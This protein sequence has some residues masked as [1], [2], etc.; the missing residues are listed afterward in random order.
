MNVDRIKDELIK[1]KNDRFEGNIYYY[2]LVYFLYNSNKIEGYPSGQI[3]SFTTQ[4]ETN[5]LIFY[6]FI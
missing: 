6:Y 2:L 1:Q 5:R 4:D 3:L